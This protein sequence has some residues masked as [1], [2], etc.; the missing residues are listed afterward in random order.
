MTLSFLEYGVTER[1]R[2]S[3]RKKDFLRYNWEDLPSYFNNRL[4]NQPDKLV[5]ETKWAKANRPGYPM[6]A[7][8]M[9]SNANVPLGNFPGTTELVKSIP[10]KDTDQGI[11]QLKEFIQ[12]L[13]E[14]IETQ[15]VVAQF[16]NG[17][18]GMN[19]ESIP[20]DLLGDV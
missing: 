4:K 11:E 15:K 18:A 8:M 5:R 7:R 20:S 3:Q 1:I 10:C 14:D 12:S 17:K 16:M 9:F 13:E 2:T 6:E 19:S